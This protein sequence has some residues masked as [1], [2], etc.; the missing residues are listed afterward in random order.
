MR[1]ISRGELG[2][3]GYTDRKYM[4]PSEQDVLLNLVDS[5]HPRCMLE[6]GVN[7]GLTAQAV[8][9]R[10][11]SIERYIG[12]D[13]DTRYRFELAAQEIERP[14]QPGHLVKHDPRFELVLVSEGREIDLH[15]GCDVV[16]IDGDHG[17]KAVLRDTELATALVPPGGM[18]IWHDY[19]N[20]TVQVTAALDE[21]VASGRNL[22]HVIG[23]W[24][25]FEQ[26]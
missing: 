20:P 15:E 4:Q 24:L 17:R 11:E 2:A 26:R 21:L 6:I 23:T 8:L 12:V 3:V 22:V 10:V 9:Q 14:R 1:L 5:V 7:I 25:V 18:I 19:G 16:F 13:V